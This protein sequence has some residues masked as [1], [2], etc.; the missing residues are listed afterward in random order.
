MVDSGHLL[1]DWC[2][3]LVRPDRLD[4]ELMTE[5][6]RRWL[7][8]DYSAHQVEWAYHG[9]LPRV[10]VEE[11]LRGP[12]GG[13]PDEYNLFVLHGRVELLFVD[14]RRY[15]DRHKDFYLRDWT[16]VDVQ[17][18]DIYPRGKPP[19]PRLLD[20]IVEVAEAL[21]QETDFVR[22]DLYETGDRVV[23]GELT[24]YPSGGEKNNFTPPS[25]DD[26]LGRLWTVP[27]R[28]E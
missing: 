16:P 1:E 21:G 15:V 28:Y 8:M 7:T 20:R 17:K 24:N 3:V 4:W 2:W 6:F 14:Q 13:Q 26:E 22:V 25:Y 23:F 27:R 10:L 9:V 5:S 18:G 12:D 11:R 19:R